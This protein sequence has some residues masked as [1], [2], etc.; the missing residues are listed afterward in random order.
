M[1][2]QLD[3]N[4]K[5]TSPVSRTELMKIS[6]SLDVRFDQRRPSEGNT[7]EEQKYTINMLEKIIQKIGEEM[8]K[9]T[10]NVEEKN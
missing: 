6:E 3:N 2:D 10:T 7:L 9:F 4:G 5:H 8:D 1:R